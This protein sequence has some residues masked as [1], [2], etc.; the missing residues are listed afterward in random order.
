MRYQRLKQQRGV[1]LI[2]AVLIVALVTA[3]AVAMASRQQLDI[4]RSAN[5]FNNDIAYQFA[6]GAEDY[7]RN[8]LEWDITKAGS[9]SKT[10]HLGEDWAQAVAVPVEGAMLT[11]SVHDLNG[12]INLNSLLDGVGKANAEMQKRFEHLLQLLGL[13]KEIAQAVMDWIDADINPL[14]NGGAEDDYYMLQTPPYRAANRMMVSISELLL[15]KG[16]D[17][18]AYQ[19]LLPHVSALPAYDTAINVNTASAEVLAS[20]ADTMTIADGE[21]LVEQRPEEGFVNIDDF[22]KDLTTNHPTYKDVF[23]DV[24]SSYFLVDAVAEFDESTAQ[25]HSLLQRNKD[26][27]VDVLM[28]SR[29][30]F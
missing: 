18:E 21:A 8:V 11:G 2:T 16:V 10:D 19:L 23:L 30:A 7:A 13:N 4:R 26:G 25:L 14:F 27:G 28:R 17:N 3:T 20:L 15:V 12:R 29:G 22:G 1:A 5:I 6:L 24:Q 9:N